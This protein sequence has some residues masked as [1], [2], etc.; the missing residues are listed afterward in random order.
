M[1]ISVF[2]SNQPRRLQLVSRLAAV[3]DSVFT[4][5][6]CTTVFPGDVADFFKKPEVMQCYLSNVVAAE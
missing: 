1:K 2:A 4:V 3:S 5:R 6:E